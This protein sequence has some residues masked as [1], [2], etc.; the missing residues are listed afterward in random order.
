MLFCIYFFLYNIYIM[1]LD[2]IYTKEYTY[3]LY[4]IYVCIVSSIHIQFIIIIIFFFFCDDSSFVRRT[5]YGRLQ[6]INT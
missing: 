3:F 1:Y 5:W 4:K 6:N 2:D